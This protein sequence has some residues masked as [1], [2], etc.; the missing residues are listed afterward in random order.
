M[1]AMTSRTGKRSFTFIELLIVILIIAILS[2]ISIPR[3]RN[4]FYGFR[5]EG[6]A[7]DVYYLSLYLQGSAAAKGKIYCLNISPDQRNFR[8]TQKKEDVAADENK[9]EFEAVKGNYGKLLEAPAGVVVSIEPHPAGELYFY[10]DASMDKSLNII[11]TDPYNKKITLAI[12]G[13]AG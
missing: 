2:A 11:F 1:M 3:L 12:K 7:K 10:P 6:F 13:A 5:L 9:D 4:A 8:A